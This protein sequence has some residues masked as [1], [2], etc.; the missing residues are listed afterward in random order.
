LAT[1]AALS[2]AGCLPSVRR[3]CAPVDKDCAIGNHYN[4]VPNSLH[5]VIAEKTFRSWSAFKFCIYAVDTELYLCVCFLIPTWSKESLYSFVILWWSQV[6]INFAL[7]YLCSATVRSHELRSLSCTSAE[8]LNLV[9]CH[10]THESQ[11]AS[12]QCAE[13]MDLSNFGA[14]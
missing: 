13:L 5:H 7:Y 10:R 11:V 14:E 2:C 12:D 6:L 3:F 1:A 9:I 8:W 4:E